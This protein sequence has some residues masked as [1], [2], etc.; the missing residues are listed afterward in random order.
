[1]SKIRL[2]VAPLAAAVALVLVPSAA[3]VGQYGDP[4]GDNGTA[5]DVTG[6]VVTSDASG[7]VFFRINGNGLS[8]SE[9]NGTFLILDT[10][11]NPATGDPDAMGAE[12]FFYVDKDTYWFSRWDGSDWVDT[13]YATVRVSGGSRGLTLSVNRSEL[14]N[15]S[16]FNFWVRSFDDNTKQGDDAPDD[17]MFNYS[18]Q[19]QGVH[20]LSAV[21]AT[22][23]AAGPKAGKAFALSVPGLKLPPDGRTISILDPQPESYACK[24]SLKGRALAGTGKS[25]C[26]WRLPKTARGKTLKVVVTVVFEGTSASF[27][28]SFKVR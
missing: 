7:Q 5:G 23:P 28:Y 12:Y 22:T 13:S 11:A 15:T 21:V 18:L 19:L 3:A 26:A 20:I 6:V 14:G 10:D 4:A 17:G 25:G 1:M 2:Y 27:P 16:E 8:T 9:T 24:A